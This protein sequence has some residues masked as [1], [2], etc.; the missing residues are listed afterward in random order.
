MALIIFIAM[1]FLTIPVFLIG[2]ETVEHIAGVSKRII[3]DHEHLAEKAIWLMGLLGVISLFSFYTINKKIPFA[4]TVAIVTFVNSIV[5]FSLFAKVGKS[6]WKIRH[7]E[8]RT[9]DS[10]VQQQEL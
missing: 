4:R 5:T 9:S 1:S 8:I 6:G 3:E 10:N 7:Y 2:E